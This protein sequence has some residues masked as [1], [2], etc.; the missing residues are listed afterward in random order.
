LGGMFNIPRDDNLLDSGTFYLTD[1]K[2]HLLGQHRDRSN[3]L[4]EVTKLDYNAR[5]WTI[6]L[7]GAQEANFYQGEYPDDPLI[8][9]EML[10]A[11]IHALQ[12]KQTQI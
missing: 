12:L 9:G 2:L 7:E 5:G 10:E 11:I 3:R 4:S 1:N 6:I 8:D